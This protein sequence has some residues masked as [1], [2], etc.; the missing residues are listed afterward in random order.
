MMGPMLRRI[1]GITSSQ[2]KV[3]LPGT[4]KVDAQRE[5]CLSTRYWISRLHLVRYQGN[6]QYQCTRGASCGEL[7]QCQV[8]PGSAC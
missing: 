3:K 2:R 8:M 5:S 7:L 4:E 1:S 6:L